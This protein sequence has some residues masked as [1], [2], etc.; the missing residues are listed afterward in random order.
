MTDD[1]MTDDKMKDGEKEDGKFQTNVKANVK[2]DAIRER[3]FAFAVRVVK[4]CQ[5]LEKIQKSAEI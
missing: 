5:Y 4:L 2:V 3:T 1:K